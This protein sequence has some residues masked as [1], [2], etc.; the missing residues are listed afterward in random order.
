MLLELSYPFGGDEPKWPTN[1]NDSYVWDNATRRGDSCNASTVRHHMH[2]G[3]HVDAPRHFTMDGRTIDQIPIEDFCYR[4]PLAVN[5]PKG[6]GGRITKEDLLPYADQLASCDLL[7]VYT[8]YADLRES[9]PHAFIDDF[10]CWGADAARYLRR[11]CPKLKAVAMDVLSVDSCTTGVSEG[12]PAHHAF[13]DV[14]EENPQRTLLLFEDVNTKKLFEAGKPAKA[15]FAFPVRF[16]G[17]E[18][19]PIAMVAEL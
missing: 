16:K 12:F 1:P 11:E 4:S 17:L 19:A 18:A 15:V 3:T 13:L 6:K 10:P 8:G 7:L 5:I 9:D 14:N 2:N